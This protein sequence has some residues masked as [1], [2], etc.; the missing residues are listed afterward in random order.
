[1]VGKIVALF[2]VLALPF[3]LSLWHRSS[4]QPSV[5]RYDVTLYKSMW[6]HLNRGLCGIEILSMP[7]RTPSRSRFE[8][9]LGA[10]VDPFK[11]SFR[12]AS[13]RQGEN[14]LTVLVFPLWLPNLILFFTLGM[15]L[16]YGP[17]RTWRRKRNGWC[18]WCGYDLTGN[19]SGRCPECGMTTDT[20]SPR[21]SS[22]G[23]RG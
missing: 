19:R 20:F 1:M 18:L 5:R 6:V 14:Q 11:T 9:R 8:S 10:N 16:T 22:L 17:V 4:T 12:L 15:A 3:S 2:C 21:W 23:R 7:S 13:S